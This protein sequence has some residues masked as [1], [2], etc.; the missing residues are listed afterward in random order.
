[1]TLFEILYFNRELIE[2]LKNLGINLDDCRYI[3]L[4]GDYRRMYCQGDKVTYIVSLLSEKYDVS[5]RK[6]YSIIKRFG[7]Y[8]T[9]DA[10]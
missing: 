1:M 5:E 10:V 9:N 6:I 7:T 8:C 4:Y 2:K 3:D